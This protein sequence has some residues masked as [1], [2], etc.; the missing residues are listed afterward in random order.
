MAGNIKKC[1]VV[2]ASFILTFLLKEESAITEVFRS[3]INGEIQFI[4]S[5]LLK[6]EIGNGLRSA[7]LKKRINPRTAKIIYRDFFSLGISEEGP[8]PLETLR[9]AFLR[10]ISFYD[11]SY[12]VLSRQKG[13]PLL[14]RDKALEIRWFR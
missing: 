5:D 3:Y 9:I 2:E 7:V 6:Y 13:W 12:L 10:N 14:T 8:N 11:A 1:F 4:T